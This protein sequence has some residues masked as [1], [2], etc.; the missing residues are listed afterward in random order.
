MS[1]SPLAV[2]SLSIIKTLAVPLR[3]T[4]HKL[5]TLRPQAKLQGISE[6][7]GPQ[8]CEVQARWHVDTP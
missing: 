6:E 3:G 5:G 7:L 8:R 4:T 1:K 2:H